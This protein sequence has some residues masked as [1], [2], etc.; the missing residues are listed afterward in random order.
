MN[1]QIHE[2][3][4]YTHELKFFLKDPDET[5]YLEISKVLQNFGKE[6]QTTLHFEEKPFCRMQLELQAEKD[7]REDEIKKELFQVLKRNGA[8]EIKIDHDFFLPEGEYQFMVKTETG[9]KDIF[10]AQIEKEMKRSLQD[11][12]KEVKISGLKEDILY[13][14][15]KYSFKFKGTAQQ[16]FKTSSLYKKIFQSLQVLGFVCVSVEKLE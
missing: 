5:L 16:V 6:K 14:S 8:A 4:N 15:A 12:L 11:I 13:G 3:G 7:F 10:K 2:K 9:K 1:Y